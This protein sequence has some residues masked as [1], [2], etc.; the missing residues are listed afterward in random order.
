[1]STFEERARLRADWAIRVIPL[2]SEELT[3][4]RDTSTID[5]RIALVDTLTREQWRLAKL[6]IPSY[7]RAAMPGR[8]TRGR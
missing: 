2:G 3:D 8:L 4:P 6:E 5:E 7:G 1:M